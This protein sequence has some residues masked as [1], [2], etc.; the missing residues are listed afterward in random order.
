MRDHDRVERIRSGLQRLQL[1]AILCTLPDYVLLLSGYWPVIGASIAIATSEGRIFLIVPED[2]QELARAGWADDILT[3][4]PGRLDRLQST[5]EA[6]FQALQECAQELGITH[7]RIGYEHGAA[8]EPASYVAMYLYGASIVQLLVE[9]LPSAALVSADA[10]LAIWAM[11]K[12]PQEVNRI[13]AACSLAGKAFIGGASQLRSGLSETEAAAL[14]RSGLSEGSEGTGRNGVLRADGF[15]FCMSGPN[16]AKASGAYAL[17]RARKIQPADLALIHCNS[18]TDGFWT[19]ITRTYSLGALDDRREQVYRA[20]FEAR[21]AALAAIRPGVRA[22][23]VDYAARSVLGAH[24]FENEFSHAT[25]HGIGFAAIA[26]NARP[27]I[28]PKSEEQLQEGMVF[29]IEPAVYLE[30]W[31]G[32]RHCDM[33]TVTASGAEVLTPFHLRFEDLILDPHGGLRAAA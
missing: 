26:H 19:D 5:S 15:A 8:S 16:S 20:I 13:R 14:F 33:V 31:G 9:A 3:F 30:G 21:D 28:H 25:G 17:S 29:N 6:A 11:L 10:L 23:T 1:D 2:E 4:K 18:Y 12:T 27:R 22:S 24:G 32:V 7:A